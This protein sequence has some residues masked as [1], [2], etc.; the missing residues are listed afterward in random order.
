MPLLSRRRTYEVLERVRGNDRTAMWV[1]GFIVVLVFINIVAVIIESVESVYQAH[2]LAFDLIEYVSVIVFG[3]EYLLRLW[4]YAENEQA[5]P[6][7][8]K[9]RWRYATSLFG[10]V[11]LIAVV[12]TILSIFMPGID[13]TAAYSQV[14]A[15]L[16]RT[17]RSR[18]Q[19]LRRTT[20]L[21]GEFLRARRCDH[22]G[23]NPAVFG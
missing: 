10:L 14:H 9:R 11:D 21:H 3:A 22:H 4:A 23:V 8:V 1:N 2:R 6:T 20:R 19:P 15:L 18:A 7:V 16:L 5:G 13:S 12:P 17:S